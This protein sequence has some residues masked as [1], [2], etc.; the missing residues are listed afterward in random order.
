MSQSNDRRAEPTLNELAQS[1]FRILVVDDDAAIRATYRHILQPPPSELGGL[2]ALIS[3]ADAVAGENLFKVVDADQGET[4]A[5]LQRD[6]MLQGQRF[7]LAFIDMRMPPGW[8]GMRTAVALRAQDPSI[9]IVIAT[10]F[11]DYDVNELQRALGHDVVL[12]RKPFNQEEVFQLA[13][14]LCQSWET[15]Q[16]LEAVTAEMESRVIARTA[17][18]D[19]RNSL[20]AVMVEISTRFIESSAENGI[21][22]A[23]NWSLARLG[24]AIDVDGCV[25]YCFDKAQDCY[26]MRHEWH[27]L[28]VDALPPQLHRLP[29]N[30]MAPA[31]AR[32][33][34]SESFRFDNPSELPAEMALLRQSLTGYYKGVLAVPLEIGAHLVGFVAVGMTQAERRFDADVEKM[35]LATGHAIASAL[36]ANEA[37]RRLKESQAMLRATQQAARIGNWRLEADGQHAWWDAQVSRILGLGPAQTP[38]PAQLL[39]LTHPDDRPKLQA[40]LRAGFERGE[41]SYLEY[42]I[43]RSE[44]RQSWVGCW[45]EPQA[46]EDGHFSRLVGMMQDVTERKLAELESR[47][48][49][50]IVSS[51]PDGIALLDREYRYQIVNQT[52]ERYSGIDKQHLVGMTI[53]DHLGAITFEKQI[54]SK[55][56]RCLAGEILSYADWFEFPKL[57]RR[58]VTVTYFPYLDEDGTVKGVVTSTRDGTDLQLAKE[59]L[60]DSESRFRGIVEAADEGVWQVD[61]EWRTTY[62]N[63]RME[64]LLGCAPGAM[65]GRAITDFMDDAGSEQLNTLQLRREKGV[66]EAHDFSFLR[67]DGG[68]LYALLSTTPM[69]NP[70]GKFVGATAMVSDISRRVRLEATLTATAELVSAPSRDDIAALLVRHA[71]ERLGLDYIHIARLRP[72]ANSVETEAAWLD[73]QPISNWSYDLAGSPCSEVL[74]SRRQLIESGVRQQYPNDSDLCRISAEGYVG[75]PIIDSAGHVL[76]LIVGI[77]RAPLQEGDMVQANL[78]ILAASMAMEWQQRQTLQSLRAER[79]T[80]RNILHTVETLIVALDTSGRI[81]LINR[82][83]CQ[84]LGYGEAELLGQDWF[85]LCLPQTPQ[86]EEVRAVFRKG[87]TADLAGFEYFENPVCTRSGELRLIAWHNSVIRDADGK[88]IGGLSAGED[89]TERRAAEAQIRQMSGSPPGLA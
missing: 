49:Q 68:V 53:A 43:H 64:E 4:A 33:L 11:S 36:D 56:D 47:K 52:Y 66:R 41:P 65:S 83:A 17:E 29:R 67:A 40:N 27:A 30:E 54:K 58:Y 44:G 63:R 86:V 45:I 21:D 59:A 37:N 70:S 42:R 48:S 31:H 22:D 7:P 89:I 71:G 24:R 55:F 77:T 87:L 28:G 6:A 16:R 79:D 10:A 78:R 46:G 82:K 34:R 74:Q 81:T 51:T 85:T 57:G 69:F 32:F 18:L 13:R 84:L 26:F 76:G 60:Q 5:N 73:A 3:G 80:T 8:D 15:R 19:R 39:E 12:L 72:D 62:V 14:T 23:V 2:E 25:M 35:L 20:Q 1:P 9:Y 50:Y 38:N 75:E 88:V 61:A